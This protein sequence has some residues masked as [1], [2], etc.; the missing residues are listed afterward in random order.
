REL[1]I[2]TVAAHRRSAFE[3]HAHT[4]PARAAGLDEATR[5]AVRAGAGDA[6]SGADRLVWRA[7]SS[8]LAER[9]LDEGT[10]AELDDLAGVAGLVELVTLVGYYDL[11]AMSMRTFRVESPDGADGWSDESR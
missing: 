1:A 4:E 8:L 9:D 3:W 6:L 2:L 5:A 11:L 7:V 10:V